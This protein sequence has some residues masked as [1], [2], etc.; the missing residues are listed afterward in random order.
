MQVGNLEMGLRQIR[1]TEMPLAVTLTL[2]KHELSLFQA[3]VTMPLKVCVIAIAIMQ[4]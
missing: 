1:A 4:M 2:S 3:C